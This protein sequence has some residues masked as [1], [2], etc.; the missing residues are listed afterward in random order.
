MPISVQ[1]VIFQ[2]GVDIFK[3]A[4]QLCHLRYRFR[5]FNL[6]LPRT[7]LAEYFSAVSRNSV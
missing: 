1:L 3:A 4:G 7:I 6:L 5:T 2:F